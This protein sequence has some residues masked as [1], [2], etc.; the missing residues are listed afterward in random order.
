MDTFQTATQHT[1]LALEACDEIINEAVRVLHGNS[2]I[3]DC[4]VS[5]AAVCYF[6]ENNVTAT[7]CRRSG[8]VTY[9]SVE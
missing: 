3:E 5:D 1:L 7:V 6:I 2:A 4:E 9:T 8:A